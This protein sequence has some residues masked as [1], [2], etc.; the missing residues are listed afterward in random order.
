[1]SDLKTRAAGWY[2]DPQDPQLLRW[3]EGSKW[4]QNTQAVPVEPARRT[5][6]RLVMAGL[7]VTIMVVVAAM[8]LMFVRPGLQADHA[9][10]ASA[11]AVPVAQVCTDTVAAL[12][13]DGTA[14][15]IAARLLRTADGVDLPGAAAFFATAGEQS[16]IVLNSTG[17][18][19]LQAVAA[20][21][22][23]QAYGAFVTSFSQAL[24]DG[25]TIVLDALGKK[26]VLRPEQA[27]KLREE[28]QALTT[29]Q[30][31]VAPSAP[32]IPTSAP[33]G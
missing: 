12:T 21:Q 18:A 25:P 1:M 5:V 29:A 22:A 6:P 13:A 2:R 24:N 33:V 7:I 17:S 26:G 14:G 16:A 3:W 4:T 28:A 15:T 11:P 23:P 30:T 27:A 10:V 20:H 19:C 32:A 8:F 9:A 31:A